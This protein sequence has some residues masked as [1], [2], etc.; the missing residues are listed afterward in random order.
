MELTLRGR[1]SYFQDDAD[2]YTG[3]NTIDLATL[4]IIFAHGITD[5]DLMQTRVISATAGSVKITYE[6]TALDPAVLYQAKDTI[7]A[8]VASGIR[9]QYTSGSRA[10][11]MLSNDV[12]VA[13]HLVSIA[14]W[15]MWSSWK[16]V[17]AIVTVCIL[18]VSA[19]C[20]AWYAMR[21]CR[22]QKRTRAST[23]TLE[24]SNVMGLHTPITPEDGNARKALEMMATIPEAGRNSMPYSAPISPPPEN[25]QYAD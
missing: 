2:T 4:V 6:L 7:D 20:G 3:G 17:V 11:K 19:V 18:I 25:E 8:A 13:M 24:P 10:Y 5:H 1:W 16:M 12:V 23:V 21:K 15:N 9:W 14:S 22:K